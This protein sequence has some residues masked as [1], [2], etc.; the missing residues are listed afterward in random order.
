MNL[1]FRH[2]PELFGLEGE[3]RFY[4]FASGIAS[5]PSIPAFFTAY[6]SQSFESL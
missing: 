2:A 1:T 4:H 5:L 6:T 3:E